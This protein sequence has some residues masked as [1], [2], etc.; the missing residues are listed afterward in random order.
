MKVDRI[1]LVRIAEATAV[2][3]AMAAAFIFV[4]LSGSPSGFL[5]FV[6]LVLLVVV[7]V[8]V[9]S[10]LALERRLPSLWPGDPYDG[11]ATR[12]AMAVGV[13][14]FVALLGVWMLIGHG[15]STMWIAYLGMS[16]A[17]T[18]AGILTRRQLV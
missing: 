12:V 2:W 8:A 9:V 7:G 17:M 14:A 4:P 5:A 6:G 10:S 11:R 16:Y 3:L 13:A 15:A 18:I 1:R